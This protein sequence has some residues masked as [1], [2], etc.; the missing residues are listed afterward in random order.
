[1]CFVL[2]SMCSWSFDVGVALPKVAMAVLKSGVGYFGVVNWS[3]KHLLLFGYQY[4]T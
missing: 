3:Q 4:G 1:M 2:F